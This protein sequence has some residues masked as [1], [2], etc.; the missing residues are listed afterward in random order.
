[1]MPK[2]DLKL[3]GWMEKELEDIGVTPLKTAKTAETFLKDKNGTAM[4]LINSVCGCAAGAARPGVGMALQNKK[5]PDRLATVFAGVDSEATEKVRSFLPEVPPSSP[6]VALFKDGQ[7]VHFIPRSEIEGFSYEQ[8][9]EKLI[10][11]FDEYCTAE[12]PSVSVEAL[13]EAFSSSG[14]NS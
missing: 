13:K 7:M 6:S 3:V 2:Y 8:I 11:A 9:A 10:S 5:I 1:M 14:R 12:G 4:V